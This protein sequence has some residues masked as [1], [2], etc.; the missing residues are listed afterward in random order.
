[1]RQTLQLLDA[2]GLGVRYRTS[3]PGGEEVEG[4]IRADLTVAVRGGVVPG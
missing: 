1:M 2:L 4:E 3:G